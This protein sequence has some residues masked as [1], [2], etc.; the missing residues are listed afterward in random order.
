MRDEATS[1]RSDKG[2]VGVAIV[3]LVV[4]G[5]VGAIAGSCENETSAT[6]EEATR[7]SET[8]R[9]VVTVT[10]EEY[11]DDW[12]LTVPEAQLELID[13]FYAVVHARGRTYAMNGTARTV[14]SERGW[15]DIYEIW[16]EGEYGRVSIAP[17]LDRTLALRDW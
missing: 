15:N 6:K 8:T 14:M 2:R 11:G 4:L 9:K 7:P 5:L 1:R 3:V 12:P 10:Q 17:L 13:G 16:R